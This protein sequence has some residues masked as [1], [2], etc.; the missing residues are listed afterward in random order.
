MDIDIVGEKR[1]RW[2][3]NRDG[4][5]IYPEWDPEKSKAPKKQKPKKTGR[6]WLKA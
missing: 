2:V 3:V 6:E 5:E 4:Y 1:K